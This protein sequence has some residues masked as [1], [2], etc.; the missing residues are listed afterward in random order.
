ME[1]KV[2]Y[3]S[4]CKSAKAL[5]AHFKPGWFSMVLIVSGTVEFIV[6]STPIRLSTGQLYAVP[7]LAKA[8]TIVSPI[9]FYL[10]SCTIAFAVNNRIARYGTGYIEAITD[11]SSAILSLSKVEMR[12]ML[13]LAELLK[14]K[15]SRQK[16][17]VFQDEM[18]LLCL[19]LILYEYSALHYRKSK[20]ASRVHSRKEKIVMDFIELL[21]K[22]SKWHH[23]VKFYADSL[24]VS[25]G[26]LRKAVHS[27]T[28]MSAKYFIEM[29]V[30][31]EAYLLL[32]IEHLS[33]TEISDRLN[34]STLSS[35]SGFFKKY[36]KLSP[37]QYRLKLR[38]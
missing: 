14:K 30:L 34:F 20:N 26:H 9:K 18:I 22:H 27:L 21:D 11:Q 10:V 23:D 25:N 33:I 15:T 17:T 1:L 3:I 13:Q 7:T 4:E 16:H 19:N 35:F 36:A 31:S 24:F 29:S 6:G 8:A 5:N 38:P 28:G 12:H 32:A 37:T 2:L